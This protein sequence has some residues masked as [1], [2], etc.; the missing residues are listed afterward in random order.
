[1]SIASASFVIALLITCIQSASTSS[2]EPGRSDLIPWKWSVKPEDSS[3]R[4][5]ECPSE[6]SILGTFGIINI[7]V[8]TASLVTGHR[9]FVKKITC[10]YFGRND[11]TR[12]WYLLFIFPLGLQLDANAFIG[13]LYG[14][15]PGYGSTFSIVDLMLF[16]TT[17]PRLSW[18]ILAFFTLIDSCTWDQN[19]Y[20]KS[21]K[22]ALLAEILLQLIASYYTGT[23]VHFASQHGYYYNGHLNGQY[24]T[25]AKLM[26]AGAMISLIFLFLTLIFLIRF[27]IRRPE[28]WD[29]YQRSYRVSAIPLAVI[30]CTTW[31]GSWLFWAGYVQLAGDT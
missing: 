11:E 9:W 1:M 26:Y 8:S 6:L 3:D 31:L 7:L 24:A 29:K 13:Y 28:H 22:A 2:S 30:S 21:T 17:R 4:G 10:G 15:A 25:G 5:G 20:E 19:L 23:T 18:L 14:T 16:Y 12:S 27:V